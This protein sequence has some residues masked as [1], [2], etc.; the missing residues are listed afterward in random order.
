MCWRSDESPTLGVSNTH[1]E[2]LASYKGAGMPVL[3]DTREHSEPLTI[4]CLPITYQSFTVHRMHH[5]AST[6]TRTVDSS[7][8]YR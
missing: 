7:D 4:D 6:A 5:P 2:T 8:F 1:P 3:V